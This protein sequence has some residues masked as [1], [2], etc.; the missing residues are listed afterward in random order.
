MEKI[1]TAMTGNN[2]TT[3]DVLIR[4]QVSITAAFI[5]KKHSFLHD[6]AIRIYVNKATV[7]QTS[8]HLRRQGGA[9]AEEGEEE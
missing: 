2:I 5:I 8:M 7:W 3:K 6:I 9:Y 1:E 4:L